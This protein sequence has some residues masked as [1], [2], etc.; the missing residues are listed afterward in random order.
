MMMIPIVKREFSDDPP[1]MVE[2]SIS[3]FAIYK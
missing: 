2:K 3:G 1:P